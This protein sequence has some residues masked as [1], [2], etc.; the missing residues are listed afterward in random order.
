MILFGL[1]SVPSL[2]AQK[3]ADGHQPFVSQ[4]RAISLLA[5]PW[6]VP[7]WV[8]KGELQLTLKAGWAAVDAALGQWTPPI[9]L[10]DGALSVPLRE[11]RDAVQLGST[12]PAAPCPSAPTPS[13]KAASQEPDAVAS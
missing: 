13:Q 12:L 10:K 2:V 4:A 6:D 1:L 9:S 7:Y 8:E 11:R 5:R 3:L